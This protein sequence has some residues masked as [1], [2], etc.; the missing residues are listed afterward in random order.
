M[1]RADVTEFAKMTSKSE[2]YIRRL[3][4]E[5]RLPCQKT[6][7]PTGIKYLIYLDTD[8]ANKLLGEEQKLGPH[9]Y[10]QEPKSEQKELIHK[11]LSGEPD[12][13]FSESV[14]DGEIVGTRVHEEGPYRNS[15]AFIE[16]VVSELID[17]NKKLVQY[18]E[19]AGQVKLLTDNSQ[20][21][22]SEY[23]KLKYENESLIKVNKD[24]EIKL[25]E[26]ES[27]LKKTKEEQEKNKKFRF[28]K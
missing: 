16:G 24:L 3:C 10:G 9:G 21:Y 15:S 20:F 14:I 27:E 23:F 22:Q 12:E 19:V 25:K 18:A 26:L 28:W 2:R 1:K 6:A 8:E 5:G 17:V 13:L 11:S 7:V 4:K